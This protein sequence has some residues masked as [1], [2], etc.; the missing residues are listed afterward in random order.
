MAEISERLLESLERG[1]ERREELLSSSSY[2]SHRELGKALRAVLE[3]LKCSGNRIEDIRRSTN[4]FE[5]HL[6]GIL[7]EDLRKQIV[8]S[9]AQ[10]MRAREEE[11]KIVAFYR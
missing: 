7:S 4:C 6:S 9:L 8:K 2:G 10:R 5:I 11:F 3:D 1:E